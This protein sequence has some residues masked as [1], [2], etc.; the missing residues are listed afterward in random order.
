M[1]IAYYAL[2]YGK[3][4]LAHS[5]R[6]VQGAVDEI[7]MLYTARPSFG[8]STDAKNPDSLEELKREAHRFAE[9][10]IIWHQADWDSEGQHRD[11][12]LAVARVRKASVIATVDADELWDTETLSR[13]LDYVEQTP[14]PGVGRYRASFLHFWRS[15]DYVCR[16]PCMPERVIDVRSFPGTIDYLPAEI[17]TKP[18]YHFGYAQSDALMQYKWKIHGHQADLRPAWV[19]RFLTWQP[20]EMDV[21]PTNLNF[22]NPE[23]IDDASREVVQRL[24]GDHPYFGRERIR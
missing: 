10:P 16:D 19:D 18:V 21:H 14:K 15:L 8:V 3:E 13:C 11:T 20:G 2:H 24:L 22:W 17:Q 5:V 12:I 1:R 9:K 4:Y 23:R 6:S 7:H